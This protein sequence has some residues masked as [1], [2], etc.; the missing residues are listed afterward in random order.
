MAAVWGSIMRRSV[1][2]RSLALTSVSAV[3]LAGSA[4][5]AEPKEKVAP[6]QAQT[7]R[8]AAASQMAPAPQAQTAPE[9]SGGSETDDKVTVTARRVEEKLQDTPVAVTAFSEKQLERLGAEN[10]GGL[11][12]SVPNL[13]LVQGRGSN[14]S[15]NIFIR[16]VGQPDA[17][18]TFDPAVGVYID[19][20]YISRIRGAL[21][22]VYDMAR[23]E[24]LRGPQG[25]L[26]GK[27]TI[28][29]ALKIVTLKPG[30][31]FQG[32]LSVAVGDY[33][34]LEVRARASGALS[35]TVRAGISLY[36][37]D[38]D[39][40]VTDPATGLDYN[41]KDTMAGRFSLY[42]DPN[43]KTSVR[44]NLDYTQENPL[45]SLG[46]PE[47][48]VR[49]AFAVTLFPAPA[50]LDYDF[51]T[52]T[53][54]T[55]F[56]DKNSLDHYGFGVT[57][58]REL[59]SH[60]TLKSITAARKLDY[61]DYI[62]IDATQFRV[63]DVLVDVNQNQQSQEFQLTFDGDGS[64]R[65]V[66]GVY[67]LRERIFSHQE[68][69]AQDFFPGFVRFIDDDQ[70]LHSFA[71]YASVDYDLSPELVL[72]A[73]ARY[74]QENKKYDRLTTTVGLV[75]A[76][77]AP[78]EQKSYNDLSPS[79]TLTWN[80]G[81]T[82]TYYAKVSKGFKSGGFNG[83][84]NSA[85]ELPRT[86]DPETLWSYEAG[87][88]YAWLDGKLTMNSAFFYNTY[89]DFQARVA[90]GSGLTSVF[91][92]I[93]AGELEQYGAEFEVFYRPV[94]EL[95][96]QAQLGWLEASYAEFFDPRFAPDTNPLNDRSWNTPAFSP[97]LTLRLGAVYTVS[98]DGAG[99][100][101][102]G[103]DAAYRGDTALA[104]D[105]ADFTTRVPF[106]G[107]HQ[108]A[109]WLFN[110]RI[111]WT[112]EDQRYTI[113]AIGKNLGD[114]VYRVDAQEFS[115]LGGIRTSYFGAP[116]TFQVNVAVNF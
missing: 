46:R 42:W 72:T 97:N 18:A 19:D 82:S 22:D 30:E 89:K 112:S 21:F 115:S 113:A 74:T 96:L 66:L 78:M 111:A 81:D 116:R 105:N 109:Y 39:G 95:A 64:I 73:G 23:I 77:D 88:K 5:A 106:P 17:L 57:V 55:A 25:T 76:F 69:Y 101:D 93:N 7:I 63:G 9:A 41:N 40:Y 13:N 60:W 34:L 99:S 26:Y 35:D 104:V 52:R 108:E 65:S 36:S 85:T 3:A 71:A 107:M 94:K 2:V 86:F 16:G 1:L 61:T 27:N 20:V 54:M 110:A 50:N 6:A 84:A 28:G 102:I 56:R 49:S 38:R 10:I 15:A 43:S 11:Q 48:F 75:T 87:A 51:Q 68:A 91:S 100:V 83:R 103:G 80:P 29:G 44:V 24:V 8:T 62:D 98:L 32:R 53:S 31:E 67:A 59:S 47:N 45:I 90:R 33:N 12:N 92:V 58:T 14:S 70:T 79:L 4:M 37:A 114:E